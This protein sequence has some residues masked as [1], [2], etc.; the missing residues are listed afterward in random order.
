MSLSL[1]YLFHN[2]RILILSLIINS[3]LFSTVFMSDLRR[4]KEKQTYL[5]SNNKNKTYTNKIKI[6]RIQIRMEGSI[7]I[8]IYCLLNFFE[9]AADFLFVKFRPCSGPGQELFNF[10]ADKLREFMVEHQLLGHRCI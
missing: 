4:T 1:K 5:S 7:R 2:N 3:E 6:I 9:F 10:M 8:K